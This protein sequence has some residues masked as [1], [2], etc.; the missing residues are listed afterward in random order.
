MFYLCLGAIIG[1]VFAIYTSSKWG[2]IPQHVW[3]SWL[4]FTY[5]LIAIILIIIL[6]NPKKLHI[7]VVSCAI[8]CCGVYHTYIGVKKIYYGL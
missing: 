5:T 7:N 1:I 6:R 2:D 4:E 8:M 3:P